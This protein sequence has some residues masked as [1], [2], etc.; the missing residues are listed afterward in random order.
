M[1]FHQLRYFIAVAETGNFTKASIRCNVSQPSL[2]QQIINLEEE[3]GQKLFHRLGRKTTLT[4]AGEALL[5]RARRVVTEMDNARKEL[6]DD[7]E[8][9][10][11]VSVGAI[12]TLAPYLLPKV[13]ARCRMSHPKMEISTYED[14]WPYLL[15][16]VVQGEIDLALAALP[17]LDKR[18]IAEPLFTEPLLL[19]VGLQ[20][21]LARKERITPHDIQN[22]SFIM[23]GTSSSVAAQIRRFCGDNNIEPRVTHR[24]AQLKTVKLLVGLGLGISILPAGTFSPEDEQTLVYKTLAG[25]TSPTRE[26]ALIRHRHRYVSRGMS[27]FITSLRDAL[28][29]APIPILPPS[30]VMGAAATGPGA[31]VA[32]PLN[33]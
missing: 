1:E 13:I 16:S 19:A 22:E 17:V 18:V 20:H 21:P 7:P 31:E 15:E 5:E 25:R 32:P 9:G 24:C 12:P 26:I 30:S 2:S 6:S 23:L 11:R 27:H 14:F 4:S 33:P 10:L 8:A 29:R 28:A 3:L